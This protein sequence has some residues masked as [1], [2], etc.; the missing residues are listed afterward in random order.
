MK[1]YILPLG[2]LVASA[3]PVLAAESIV[4]N[5]AQSLEMGRELFAS[6]CAECHGRDGKG[7][8][9]VIADAGDL[10]EPL[11]YR[12]GS[13]DEAID[14]SIRDGAGAGMPAYSKELKN[15]EDVGHL[16]NYIKS[17]W[18]ADKRPAVER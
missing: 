16:R 12:N 13:T 17:L 14:R 9:E 15:P 2:L 7:H 3:V 4:P 11:L 10:T 8:V 6:R 1:K 18:P 5:T